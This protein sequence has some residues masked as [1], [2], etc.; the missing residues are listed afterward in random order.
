[1]QIRGGRRAIARSLEICGEGAPSAA[2][3]LKREFSRPEVVRS[4]DLSALDRIRPLNSNAAAIAERRIPA[5]DDSIDRVMTVA[6]ERACTQ[7]RSKWP[8]LSA[9]T[10]SRIANAIPLLLGLLAFTAMFTTPGAII[11]SILVALPTAFRVWIFVHSMTVSVDRP[12]LRSFSALP[13]EQ[14]PVYSVITA[15]HHEAEVV[16]QLL[17][18][19]ERLNYPAEKLDV[20]IAVEADDS[21]T[22]AAITARRHRV[23]ITVIPVP[24][25]ELR[26]K[27]KALNVALRFARGMFV[28]IYDAEDRPERNQLHRALKA[29]R[30]ADDSLVCVQARLCV[31]TKTSWL[32]R[33]FTAEYAG[34]FDVFLPRLARLGLPL[35][36]GGSSNHFRTA[37][38]R[39]VGGWDAH[40]VTEDADLGM[41]LARFGYRSDVIDSTTY[42]EAPA[43]VRRW[44][45]Q[46][47]RWFKG[48]M[49][50]W[51]VHMRE[52]LR[53]LRELGPHGFLTFQL[54]VGGNALVALAHP[55]FVTALGY[56]LIALFSEGCN[57]ATF[58]RIVLCLMTAVPGYSVSAS[59]YWLGLSH[60]GILKKFGILICTPVHW[61]LLSLAAWRAAIELTT[62]PHFWWKTEHG[63][64]LDS[65]RDIAIRALLGL[66]HHLS[67]LKRTGQLPQIWDDVRDSALNRRRIPPAAV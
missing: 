60:R 37:T 22:R 27:P 41:R 10:L 53:L 28:V 42:E 66:E 62:R 56:D 25:A 40:N 19:I 46:R 29:F 4:Q 48:W 54:I 24:P 50:T 47:S 12:P 38:L 1:M 39:E 63:F 52:P 23:P 7:L 2:K 51:L 3:F 61:L 45:G 35:P 36:L 59:L 21:A 58:L 32:A 34:H 15:L 6:A 30:L 55:A 44:L 17:S 65:R 26:T 8:K 57:S 64:D 33:Y 16:D 43:D 13:D 14:L 11:L 49:Q 9:A 31:D 20:I 67:E 18:A 5:I